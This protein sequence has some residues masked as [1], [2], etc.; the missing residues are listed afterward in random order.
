MTSTITELARDSF[1]LVILMEDDLVHTGEHP[2]CAD[3][4]CPRLEDRP[5]KRVN[6]PYALPEYPCLPQ[7][8]TWFEC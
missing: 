5:V 6:D 7:E 4:T 3:L 2:F 1:V 8:T